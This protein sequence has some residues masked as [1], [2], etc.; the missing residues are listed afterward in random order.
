M[1][2]QRPVKQFGFRTYT[3]DFAAAP[4]NPTPPPT[5]LY[6]I[7]TAEVDG[8]LDLIYALVNG[9]LQNDNL[10][11]DAAIA[12]SKL[13]LTG[14]IV[15]A[16]VSPTAAIDGSKLADV[17]VPTEKLVVGAATPAKMMAVVTPNL[18]AQ[19]NTDICTLPAITTRG[20]S[21]MIGGQAGIFGELLANNTPVVATLTVF[22]DATPIFSCAYKLVLETGGSTGAFI[23][24]PTP[25]VIDTVGAGTYVYKL[26]VTV[27][28]QTFG[29]SA[30]PGALFVVEFA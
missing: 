8:D 27:D 22:R 5:N 9:G 24:I 21:V 17:S 19:T 6:E 25:F 15:N 4:L 16:D 14:Q 18:T 7:Q 28:S 1:L 29:T 12:Y 23:P 30:N 11:P 2:I 13:N 20:G 10:A 26:N 3:A